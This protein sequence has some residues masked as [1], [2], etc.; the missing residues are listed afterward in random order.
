MPTK[1]I[2]LTTISKGVLIQAIG[3]Q[4]TAI[5]TMRERLDHAHTLAVEMRAFLP[6]RRRAL[7]KLLS[8]TD[9]YQNSHHSHETPSAE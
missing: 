7:A 9:T 1:A 2:D 6:R 4:R 5:L 3:E 8:I